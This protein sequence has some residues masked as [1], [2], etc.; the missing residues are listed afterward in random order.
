LTIASS[1]P[2]SGI[3]LSTTATLPTASMT[4]AFIVLFM[5]TSAID[6]AKPDRAR[7]QRVVFRCVG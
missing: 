5:G 2:G 6:F 7:P 3:G 1:G 4:N